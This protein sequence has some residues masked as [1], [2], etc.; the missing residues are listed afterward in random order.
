MGGSALLS[1]LYVKSGI[2]CEIH[3]GA[4]DMGER[5]LFLPVNSPFPGF[6]NK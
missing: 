3:S 1:A 4:W 5:F 6:P 2:A